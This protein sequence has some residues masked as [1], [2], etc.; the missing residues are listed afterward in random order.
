MEKMEK[1]NGI[2]DELANIPALLLTD[3]WILIA[4]ERKR[5]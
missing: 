4:A 3:C 5:Y 1:Q 2:R